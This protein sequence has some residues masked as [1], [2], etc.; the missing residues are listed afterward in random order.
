VQESLYRLGLMQLMHTGRDSFSI[1]TYQYRTNKFIGAMIFEKA[2]GLA[3]HSGVNT[4]SG[5]Q[6]T[7]NLRSLPP[8][9]RTIHVVLHCDVAVNVV[10]A[11][12]EVLD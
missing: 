10:A 5:S 7:I 3:G 4:R 11:G 12:I 6:L 9:A 2:L 1:S 8:A